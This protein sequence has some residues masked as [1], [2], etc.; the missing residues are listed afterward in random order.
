MH[1]ERIWHVFIGDVKAFRF[2]GFVSLG[3]PF[4][5][6]IFHDIEGIVIFLADGNSRCVVIPSLDT[7]F[8][9][10]ADH[11]VVTLQ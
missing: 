8:V 10:C 7:G 6:V 2:H 5:A 1:K 9:G 11:D 4:C 3:E